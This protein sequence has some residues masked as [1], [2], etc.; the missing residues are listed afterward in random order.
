MK[1]S[2]HRTTKAKATTARAKAP[3]A[4]A[5]A[6]TAR[7]KVA[8]KSAAR[9][10]TR[11]RGDAFIWLIAAFKLSKGLLLLAV[12]I[13]ALTLI[14][15]NVARQAARLI[16]ALRVD[17]QNHFIHALLAKL[18]RIDNQKLEALSAGSFIYAALLLT[19][20]VGLF[21][22][23][24]WAEYLTIVVTGL[25]IPLEIYELAEKFSATKLAVLAINAAVVVYL[26][27]R[28]SKRGRGGGV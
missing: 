16:A 6:A 13:G 8:S 7:A 9:R 21:L 19:E 28:V 17:P 4:R 22:R 14:N 10:G 1:R 24:H 3:A 2:K 27:V 5:K 25:L 12:A 23:K 20:G 18:T 15:E 11:R 26:I